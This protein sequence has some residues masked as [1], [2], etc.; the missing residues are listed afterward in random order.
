M[1]N[2][3]DKYLF[4]FVVLAM[5]FWMA[6]I[7]WYSGM[8][9]IGSWNSTLYLFEYEYKV[10]L[11][12]FEIAAWLATA[13]ELTAPVLLVLGLFSRFSAILLLCMT[14]VIQFTYLHVI[15]HTYWVFLLTVIIF[16]GSG[17]YSIDHFLRFS[18]KTCY[19][20]D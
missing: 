8:S 6:R 3:S 4:P 16:Y 7:F 12:P 14:G 10:P 15:E 19:N 13:I 20:K 2:F 1:A 9:K 18:C 17:R 11:V 5:R